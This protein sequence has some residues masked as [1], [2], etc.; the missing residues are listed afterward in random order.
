MPLSWR[1]K[2]TGASA[3][4]TGLGYAA[5]WLEG[6]YMIEEMGYRP[7]FLTAACLS[8]IGMAL[9]WIYLRGYRGDASEVAAI[10]CTDSL[11]SAPSPGPSARGSSGRAVGP[12]INP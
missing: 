6:G 3:A 8:I 10:M 12:S 4:M 2:M 7:L 9:V 1:T 5:T 11:Q